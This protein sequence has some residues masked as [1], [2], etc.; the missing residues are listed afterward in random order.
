MID[1]REAL[2]LFDEGRNSKYKNTFYIS[3]GYVS[4]V[5]LAKL[6]KNIFY[7]ITLMDIRYINKF[8]SNF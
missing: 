2:F 7:S 6:V 3:T 1:P 4:K 8:D 5:C